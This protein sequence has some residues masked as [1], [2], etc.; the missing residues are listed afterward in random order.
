MPATSSWIV[1]MLHM[2]L[3]AH[4]C[5]VAHVC[6]AWIQPPVSGLWLRGQRVLPPAD[7]PPALSFSGYET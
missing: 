2:R 3:V 7:M 4:R 1:A 5:P 6:I